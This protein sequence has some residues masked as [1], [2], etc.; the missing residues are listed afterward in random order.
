[1]NTATEIIENAK[2]RISNLI[3]LNLICY[4]NLVGKTCE[5]NGCYFVQGTDIMPEGMKTYTE[6]V[7]TDEE[8]N[9]TDIT[10]DTLV[11]RLSDGLFVFTIEEDEDVQ[12]SCGDVSPDVLVFI[13]DAIEKK[14]YELQYGK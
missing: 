14:V 8:R 4:C 6:A 13:S 7:F 2:E 9:I 11:V 1:M 5:S 12:L 10:I 3:A